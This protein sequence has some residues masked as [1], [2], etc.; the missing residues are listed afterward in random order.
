[1]ERYRFYEDGNVFF[2]TFSIVDW[3]PVFVSDASC[4]ILTD[5]LSFC[6]H[7]KNLGINAF[8]IMPTH[9]HGI[10]FDRSYDTENLVKTVTEFRKFTGRKIADH[11]Q[12]RTP[13]CFSDVF[14]KA[15]GVDRERR[16]WQPTRHPVQVEN[17]RFWETKFDYLHQNPVR[18]GLVN[19]SVD[20]RF[21]SA[22]YWHDRRECDVPLTTIE[23]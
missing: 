17:E 2:V 10:L 18:K 23:W 21:S 5:S 1:M 15:A 22:G 4:K 3:L 7:Q 8:V 11:W 20:W 9:F 6:H 16:V 14:R 19:R 13:S 12:N